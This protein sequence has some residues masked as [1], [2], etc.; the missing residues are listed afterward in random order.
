MAR[1]GF[2]YYVSVAGITG[3]QQAAQASIEAAVARLKAATDLPVAVGFGV[4]TPEQAAA[5]ARVAD[6][7]VVG[8]A[9]VELV[10]EHG[11]DAAGPVRDYIRSLV[12]GDPRR[13]EGSRMSWLT[14]VRNALSFVAK[15]EIARQSL[16]QVQ[17][18]RADGVRQGTG[19]EPLR[20]ARTATHHERIGPI[21]R[22]EHALRRG[23]YTILAAAQGAPR[24]RSSSATPSAMPTASRPRAPRPASAMR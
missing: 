18:L 17:G 7:V 8:S 1:A 23:S 15:R 13:A 12:D 22:F 6:G 19:G 14:R 11:A 4:R 3:L 21:V 5:I 16:A 20:S 10:G 24:T 9:I 2:L